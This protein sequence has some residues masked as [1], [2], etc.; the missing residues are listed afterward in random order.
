MQLFRWIRA[1]L[2]LNAG[3]PIGDRRRPTVL[4][5][6]LAALVIASNTVYN[7]YFFYLGGKYLVASYIS[8]LYV[9]T[10]IGV[11]VLNKKG[12][13]DVARGLLL[14]STAILLVA[15][16]GVIGK[17]S[18]AH[19][20]F[21]TVIAMLPGL[22]EY[23][24]AVSYASLCILLGG[25]FI[26][27]Q[28][29]FTADRV[30]AP[31]IYPANNIMFTISSIGALGLTSLFLYLYR[32]NLDRTEDALIAN[33]QYLHS[34]SNL[35]ALTGLP[36][37]RALDAALAR[38]WSRLARNECELTIMM[39]D[40]DYFKAYNDRYGHDAG[41]HCLKHV[42]TALCSTLQRPADLVARYGGE[43]FTILLPDT[44]AE[45]ATGLAQKLCNQ[46]AALAIPHPDAP[47]TGIVTISIGFTSA[48]PG[49]QGSLESLMKCADEALYAAKKA[50]RN[51]AEYLPYGPLEQ[52]A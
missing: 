24:R 18:G 13:H 9:L 17:E 4:T 49:Q 19:F 45:S 35:D 30:P 8:C 5:T 16:T 47:D 40:I 29:F 1:L 50:G 44:N 34:L 12:Y 43:E 6:Q 38:E 10:C 7:F 31:L 23:M 52:S 25:L 39:C 46:V 15:I 14:V 20:Y 51:R 21:F 2:E 26:F 11:I 27:C 28:L 37:R 42:A 41:D 33:N 32:R 22:F 3:I 48:G 36:N